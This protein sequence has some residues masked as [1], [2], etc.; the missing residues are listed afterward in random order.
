MCSSAQLK[1]QLEEVMERMQLLAD[2]QAG[3]RPHVCTLSLE[4]VLCLLFP[5]WEL[6]QGHSLKKVRWC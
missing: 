2:T 1:D 5:Q 4:C 3:L 6:F